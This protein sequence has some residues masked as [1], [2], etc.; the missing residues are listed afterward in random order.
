MAYIRNSA[1]YEWLKI[2]KSHD[3]GCRV[4]IYVTDHLKPCDFIDYD[5]LISKLNPYGLGEK[6]LDMS[7]G[8]KAKGHCR[9]LL[10]LAWGNS[11]W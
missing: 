3:A 1:W 10:E 8:N 9:F 4:G 11:R 6:S 2:I 5:L 7:Q